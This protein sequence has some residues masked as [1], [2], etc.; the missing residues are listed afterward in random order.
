M[1]ETIRKQFK[2][3]KTE[4]VPAVVTSK[5]WQEYHENKERK[6][7]RT[8]KRNKRQLKKEKEKS[9]KYE[10]KNKKKETN[11]LKKTEQKKMPKLINKVTK[12]LFD[13]SSGSECEHWRTSGGSTNDP[14]IDD[15]E[16]YSIC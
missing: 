11:L 7:L 8:K 4:K 14:Y 16:G 13:S 12:V 5:K 2:E 1:A 10:A 6:R 3:E 15:S 9:R